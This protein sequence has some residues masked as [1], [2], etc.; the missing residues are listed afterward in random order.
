MC[1]SAFVSA[2]QKEQSSTLGTPPRSEGEWDTDSCSL[3]ETKLFLVHTG[4]SVAW[5]DMNRE[6]TVSINVQ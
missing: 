2:V 3:M 1:Y 6:C 4:Q 5:S